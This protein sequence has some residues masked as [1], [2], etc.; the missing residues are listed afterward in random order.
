MFRIFAGIIALLGMFSGGESIPP[1]K[2]ERLP[3]SCLKYL[4]LEWLE[5]VSLEVTA[6]DSGVVIKLTAENPKALKKIYE[7]V[8]ELVAAASPQAKDLVC[9]M[10]VNRKQA[11]EG[12][13]TA[14]YQGR[15]YYFCNQ[16]CQSAFLRQPAR[17]LPM[18]DRESKEPSRCH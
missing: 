8:E 7:N 9:G 12:K 14:V 5:E 15:V 18:E 4:S 6:I 16:N 2:Q 3:F 11:K 17:F 10:A 1:N 13:L